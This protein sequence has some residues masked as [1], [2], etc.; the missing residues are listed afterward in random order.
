M[1]PFI[2]CP[3]YLLLVKIAENSNVCLPSL[4][5]KLTGPTSLTGA[6]LSLELPTELSGLCI[7]ISPWVSKGP[8]KPIII[9]DIYVFRSAIIF[10]M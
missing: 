6:P 10:S 7:I 3:V 1:F 8:E 5:M 9:P 4:P 2:F